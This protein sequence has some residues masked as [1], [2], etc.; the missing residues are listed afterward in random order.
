MAG[1]ARLKANSKRRT[2]YIAGGVA[3]GATAAAAVVWQLIR[4]RRGK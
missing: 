4:Q 3:A 2:A 1:Q